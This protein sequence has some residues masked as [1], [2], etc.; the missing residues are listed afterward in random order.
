MTLELA[1]ILKQSFSADELRAN[2]HYVLAALYEDA[3]DRTLASNVSQ[4][5]GL[6]YY[7]LYNELCGIST[8]D[9]SDT[10]RMAEVQQRLE[11]GGLLEWRRQHPI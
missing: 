7:W 4:A 2:L 9:L 11:Q 8:F 6:D 10:A 1:D 5:S 3:S